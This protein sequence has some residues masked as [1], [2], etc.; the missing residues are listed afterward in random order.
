MSGKESKNYINFVFLALATKYHY[1]RENRSLKHTKKLL[2]IK[3][4]YRK[5]ST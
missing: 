5:I 3:K 1:T 4:V 2:D